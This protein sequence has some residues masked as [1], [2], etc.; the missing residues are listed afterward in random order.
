MMIALKKHAEYIGSLSVPKENIASSFIEQVANFVKESKQSKD[1]PLPTYVGVFFDEAEQ[2]ALGSMGCKIKDPHVTVW[3]PSRGELID[4]V[5][6]HVGKTV[7]VTCDAILR[8]ETHTALRVSSLCLASGEQLP[9]QNVFSHI[10][11]VSPAGKAHESNDLPKEV[12][13]GTATMELLSEPLVFNGVV[14][15]KK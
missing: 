13:E 12:E 5:I 4:L 1:A 7:V 10:T 2:A 15:E 9:C 8:S 11:L 3:H 6:P 14:A